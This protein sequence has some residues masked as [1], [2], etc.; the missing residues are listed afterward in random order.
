MSH[1]QLNHLDE[2]IKKYIH[3][4]VYNFSHNFRNG[5]LSG[6]VISMFPLGGL[7]SM[8]YS[9]CII[10]K[11]YKIAMISSSILSII[12]NT[13]FILGIVDLSFPLIITGR[14]ITGFSENT[15]VHRHYLLYF[16]PKRK[17]DKY[18][19]YFKIIVLFGSSLGPFLSLLSILFYK[20][21]F[22]GAEVSMLSE[23]SLPGWICFLFSLILLN[24]LA[25]LK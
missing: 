9:Y 4:F 16:I 5:F 21:P 19:L 24:L 10:K 14:L 25:L 15:P 12:G 8:P 18:L 7:L 22:E 11:N 23:F 13:L 6:L 17:I 1:F 3:L 2:Y 20:N